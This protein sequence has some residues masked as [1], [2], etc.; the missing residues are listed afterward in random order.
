[1]P[2]FPRPDWLPGLLCLAC[3][4]G[5]AAGARAGDADTSL[6]EDD[7]PTVL[8][9]TRLRQA[10]A[11]TPASVTV[12]DRE[13]IRAS[14]LRT[15]PELMRFVPGMS[16]GSRDGYNYA[17]SYH[18]TNY[19]D[20]RRMQVLVDGRAVYS[21][22]L[23]NVSWM[24]IPLAIEDIERIEVTRG[25]S[26]SSYG[27]NAFLGIINIITRHPQDTPGTEASV[28]RGNGG[29]EDYRLRYGGSQG[30]AQWRMTVSTRHDDGFDHKADH[31]TD[32]RDSNDQWFANGRLS[33]TPS[34]DW[35]LDLQAG[36]KTG[37][38][39]EDPFDPSMRTMPDI[40][41]TTQFLSGTAEKQFSE[42]HSLRTTAYYQKETV[43]Q[44]WISCMPPILLSNNMAALYLSNPHYT[45]VLLD[46]GVPIGSGGTAR[47]D[48][49]ALASLMEY[50]GLGG[51]AAPDTC[52]RANNNTTQTRQQV[53]WQDTLS[54]NDRLRLVSGMALRR[55]EQSSETYLGGTVAENQLQVFAHAEYRAGERWLFN[56]GGLFADEHTAENTL[57]PRA[58]VNFTLAPG[59]VLRAIYSEA[60]RT[61]DIFE[62]DANWS[63]TLR[64]LNRPF[65]GSYT[66]RYFVTAHAPG[67]LDNERIV[68]NEIGYFGNFPDADLQLDI[69]VF[70]DR[71]KHLISEGMT[72]DGFKPDNQ[73]SLVQDGVET[74]I[75]YRPTRHVLLRATYAYIDVDSGKAAFSWREFRFT[76]QHAGSL[77]GQWQINEDW[78]LSASAY[79]ADNIN[80]RP[81]CRGDLRLARSWHWNRNE[82][83]LAAIAQHRFDDSPDLLSDNL[84]D[85]KTRWTMQGTIRF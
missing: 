18:G 37:V 70:H 30:N 82:L 36:Y 16:V 43:R 3:T 69:K 17:V 1:M 85:D 54:V 57:S 77:F 49:L 39:T 33:I 66:A 61:P 51:T 19:V 84:Y 23:A 15:L 68:S 2:L 55:D 47:D 32:R 52:G 12:L 72:I 65:H 10:Q 59:Q 79:Y 83:E 14:G 40:E 81:Y 48:A 80:Y 46:G 8:T 24:D 45:D 53:E 21:A 67:G 31:I 78:D 56:L 9:V 75:R 44:D 64:G 74:E 26:G 62:N 73:A 13:F 20:S 42:Q 7:I 5:C 25:P 38:T 58:A 35:T 29:V 71:L 60:S 63:Y 27:D 11:D 22:G 4:L 76:P 28:R 41:N 50:M 6:G 34:E